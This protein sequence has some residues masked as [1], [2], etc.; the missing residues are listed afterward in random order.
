MHTRLAI[1]ASGRGSSFQKLYPMLE[2]SKLD[3]KV[4]TVV[5]N[6]PGAEILAFAKAHG[7]HTR[8]ID[9]KDKTREQY[10]RELH[11]HFIDKNIDF[12]LLIGFM[13]ILAPSFVSLWQNKMINIHPSLLP[14]HQGLMDLKVHQA[15]IEAEEKQTGCTVHFVTEEVDAGEILLQKSCSV[16]ESETPLTLKRKVQDLEAPT[17]LKAIEQLIERKDHVE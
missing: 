13:R 12:I 15:V 16:S 1:L 11:Q 17:L 14:K 2:A 10:G 4:A 5:S 9:D 8:F 3:A 7:L 6:K